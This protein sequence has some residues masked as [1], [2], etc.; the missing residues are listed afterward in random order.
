MSSCRRIVPILITTFFLSALWPPRIAPAAGEHSLHQGFVYVADIAPDI[1]FDLRYC[2]VDNFM[3]VK[4]D[5]YRVPVAI[6]SAPAAA[7]LKKANETALSQGYVIKIFDAYRPRT[8]VDHFVRWSKDKDDL[9]N[10]K[11]FYPDI[12]KPDLFGKGFIAARSGH[13]RGSTVDVTLV[14]RATG[15]ELDMGSPFDFFGPA[16]RHGTRLITPEQ[17][18]NRTL[19]KTVMQKNGFRPYANEWWHYTLAHEPYPDRYFDF[20]VQ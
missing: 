2:G 3:G 4:V 18:A 7:A 6:L 17:A 9:K 10:K 12:D 13:S 1:L 5:G 11:R 15:T 16:S 19:L 8:A 20:P 14:D